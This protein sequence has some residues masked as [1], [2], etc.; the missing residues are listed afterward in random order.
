MVFEIKRFEGLGRLGTAS[1]G[2]SYET[3]TFLTIKRKKEAL[4]EPI[5]KIFNSSF[6]SPS[7]ERKLEKSNIETLP[8]LSPQNPELLH[9]PICILYPSLQM[10]GKSLSRLSRLEDFFPES[11]QSLILGEESYHLI[12]W[13][14]PEIYLDHGINYYKT[15]NR[16]LFTRKEIQSKFMLNI[17]FRSIQADSFNE[18]KALNVGIICLGD[19]SSLLNHPR[20]LLSY[21]SSIK[22]KISPDVMLYT[23]GVP[24]SF[25]PILTYL[26]VDLF[27]FTYLSTLN[28]AENVLE[29]DNEMRDYNLIMK[30]I[31][32]ALR[33][34]KL[35]DLVRV[36]ANSYPPQKTLLR[37]IDKQIS[38]DQ[39][40]S[41]YGTE[42]L[43]CT[44]QTDFSRP[45]VKRFRKRISERYQLGSHI[46][47]IIFL[48]CSA[49]KPYS[50]SKSHRAFQSVIR[51]TLKSRRHSI[52]EIILTSPLGIVPRELEYTYPAAHYDI[53]VTGDWSSLEKEQ[54]AQDLENF[55]NSCPDT[56]QLIGYVKGTEREVLA[57][58]CKKLKRKVN[59]IDD[60]ITSL[61]S[62]ESLY[63]FRQL[64]TENLILNPISK[65]NKLLDF[66]RVVAD[67]QFGC[68]VGKL[69]IPDNARLQGHK[70]LGIRIQYAGKH[71]MT[72]RSSTGFLT[73]SV[74]AARRILGSTKNIVRFEG[75][76]IRGT[77]IFAN[78]IRRADHEIRMNDEVI[79]VNENE[80]IIATGVAYL[81]GKLLIAMPR[82]LGIK[83]RQKVK[84]NA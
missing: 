50:Q 57:T 47:G 52:A 51:R 28:N 33:S 1:L 84:E 35:R 77:T 82:G 40:T 67:Y 23:P 21:L 11:S 34:G 58:V 30:R 45:E 3:P 15:I 59:I 69:L 66:L 54:L 61:T 62:K 5:E 12:P 53:P 79:V 25:F 13:D 22:E 73:L 9:L 7:L 83:I 41:I 56:V 74:E 10:Q 42:S 19:I 18:L 44:D 55:L 48:P 37:M 43:Y 76:S 81:P 14:L 70:E 39:G 71:L 6:I 29:L 60:E 72:F 36:H 32:S 68:G 31:K 17:P 64:L 75:E 20:Y 16:L 8:S 49:K 80:E 24:S 2:S 65:R 27:D 26:G 38:L 4:V 78:A 46:Q 63:Q